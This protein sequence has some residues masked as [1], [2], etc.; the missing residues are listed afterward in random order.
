MKLVR[1]AFTLIELLVVIAIIAILIGL[2]L[3]AVQK[4]REAAL[5][6][7]SMNNLKQINL[8]LHS[9]AA[10]HDDQLPSI[11][12]GI[13]WSLLP[14]LDGGDAIL[15]QWKSTKPNTILSQINVKVYVSPADPT[16]QLNHPATV[17]DGEPIGTRCS[18][19]ANALAFAGRPALS[20]SFPDGTSNTIAFAEHYAMCWDAQFSYTATRP[21]RAAFADRGLIPSP[22]G[23]FHMNDVIPV[24][25]GFPPVTRAST[26]GVTFQVRPRFQFT[27]E[28]VFFRPPQPNDCNP[29]I[30]QTPHEAG[31]IVGLADGSVQTVRPGI[32]ETV[33]WSAITPAGGEVASFD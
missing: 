19:A 33:F 26:P 30:P 10:A 5:R 23:T 2:L 4:V 8:A 9:H 17:G 7:Q 27:A 28:D 20:R 14:Y 12:S 1:R 24:T 29:Q 3:P 11:D 21:R 6:A 25:T 22:I 13:F 15:E 18:Y 31:M 16:L 32:A